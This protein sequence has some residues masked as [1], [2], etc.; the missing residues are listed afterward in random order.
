MFEIDIDIRRFVPFATDKPFKQQIGAFRID[1][2]HAQAVTD[3]R[4][5]GRTT[6]LAED[7]SAPGEADQVPHGQK[8]GFVVQLADQLQFVFQQSANL[9]GNPGRIP[10]GGSLPGQ[11]LQILVRSQPAGSQFLRI[12]I[13]QFIQREVTAI[14]HFQSA[15]DRLGN[16]GQREGDLFQWLQVSL[17]IGKQSIARF[18]DRDSVADGGQ[19]IVQRHSCGSVIVHIAGSQQR[20]TR[21][22][23]DLLQLLQ[24]SFIVR[25]LVQFD[26][27]IA[28]LAKK[29][30]IGVTGRLQL[31]TRLR[32]GGGGFATATAGAA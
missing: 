10:S 21:V 9:V 16:A 30:T 19:H 2:G 8:K 20:K 28:T 22:S 12:F 14:G 18:F 26:Q 29:F 24:P 3:G 32:A 23:R 17:G 27:Q 5:R 13:T 1:G 4:I 6:S 25:S 7:A 11:L 31:G 15:L